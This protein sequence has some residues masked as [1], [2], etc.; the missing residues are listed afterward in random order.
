MISR[1]RNSRMRTC[2]EA[3]FKSWD[4]VE[5]FYRRWEPTQPSADGAR[6][7]LILIHR[8]HEHSGRV[9]EILDLL[10]LDDFH[11]FAYDARG[12]GR[13]PGPRGY[14]REFDDLIKDLDQFV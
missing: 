8:G 14:A 7:A 13:S 12:H 11:A 1:G 3:L 5:L 6:R 9:Q 4:G 2:K 10:G